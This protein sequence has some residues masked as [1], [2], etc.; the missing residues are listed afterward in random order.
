MKKALCIF[1]QIQ[2]NDI[3]KFVLFE[4]EH[5][6]VVHDGFHVFVPYFLVIHKD[7]ND[8]YSQGSG[9][10][11][12]ELSKIFNLFFPK[13]GPNVLVYEHGSVGQTVPHAHM[14]I[15]SFEKGVEELI[16]ELG[17][18]GEMIQMGSLS[19]IKE[20]QKYLFF[21]TKGN[22][23]VFIPKSSDIEPV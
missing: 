1:C 3:R 14:H 6:R 20:Y 12:D 23:F 19:D 21:Y 4:T 9:A 11:Y 17:V 5:L 16:A 10:L 2:Q 13:I 22:Y 8:T 7:N 18:Q 15:L